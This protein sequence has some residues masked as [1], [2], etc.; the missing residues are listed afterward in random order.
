MY[1]IRHKCKYTLY[2]DILMI[3]MLICLTH[4][5]EIFSGLPLKVMRDPEN[6]FMVRI[7]KSTRCLLCCCYCMCLSVVQHL[8]VKRL[9]KQSCGVQRLPVVLYRKK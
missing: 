8:V 2:N 7:W 3:D 6:N 4:T 5:M 9:D 1:F